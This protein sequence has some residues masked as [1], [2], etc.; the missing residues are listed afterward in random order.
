MGYF[1]RI[2][3]YVFLAGVGVSAWTTYAGGWRHYLGLVL[4]ALATLR[5]LTLLAGR[6]R[7]VGPGRKDKS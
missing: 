6:W 1:L 7:R 3:G 5:V 4:C 2:A